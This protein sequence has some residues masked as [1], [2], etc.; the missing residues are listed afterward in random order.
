MPKT[1]EELLA[2]AEL[3]EEALLA[4]AVRESIE[5]FERLVERG[6]HGPDL[7]LLG[8][9]HLTSAPI[10]AAARGQGWASGFTSRAGRR[11]WP[12]RIQ[13][14]S[15]RQRSEGRAA[16]WASASQVSGGSSIPSAEGGR[17]PAVRGPTGAVLR[18]R[19]VVSCV[20]V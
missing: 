10:F 3:E 14:A 18:G 5:G 7:R 20:T 9:R 17:R 16:G 12:I 6:R 11:C 8:I 4:A 19:P 15:Q 13:L 1:M 2:A